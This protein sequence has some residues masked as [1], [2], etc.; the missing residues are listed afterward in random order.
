MHRPTGPGVF[1]PEVHQELRTDGG[2]LP[3]SHGEAAPGPRAL[4][5]H[6]HQDE[7]E[8][9]LSGGG[10]ARLRGETAT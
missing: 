9:H 7:N 10:E 3:H 2:E 5:Q 4:P 8:P 1:D 6:R